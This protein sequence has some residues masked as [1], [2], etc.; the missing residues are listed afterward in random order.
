M[1]ILDE[2][3]EFADAVS[4]AAVASTINV[5]DVIDTTVVRDMG[6][7]EP[8]YLVISV[9]TEVITAGA[10]GTITFQLISDSITTPATDGTATVHYQSAAFVTDDAAANAAELDTGGVPVVIALP[11]QGV[12][13]ERYLG[14]QAVI[15]T[16]TITAG[17]VN[18]YLTLVPPRWV[19]Y[20]D[21][22]N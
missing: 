3:N 9:D 16:T 21:A 5:G 17:A 18:A 15:G 6:N 10:A 4:V 13:Y 12:P 22:V 1:A 20:P 19:A 11:W 2:T 8:I 14:V 7:G